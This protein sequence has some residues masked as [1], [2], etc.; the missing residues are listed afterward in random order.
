MKRFLPLAALLFVL[1]TP[2]TAFSQVPGEIS[3]QGML[4]GI[5]GTV[6][7]TLRLYAAEVGGTV[8][9]TENHPTVTLTAGG[10]F[11]LTLG[12]IQPM[13][14]LQ[15]DRQYWLEVAVNG[16]IL[17]P[18]TRIVTS[19]Y[20]FRAQTAN[21]V[22]NNAI[23]PDDLKI[24]GSPAQNN[25][26][27]MFDGATGRFKWGALGGGGGG[28]IN[29][30]VEGDGIQIDG[31]TGPS[32]T[33][34]IA[35]EGITTAMLAN[36]AVTGAKIGAETITAAN[37]ADATITQDKFAPNVGLPSVGT[38]GGALTGNYPNPGIAN[39]A[40]ATANLATNAVTT[41][42]IADDAVTS[43]KI[44][45]GAVN[46]E[47][48]NS[49]ANFSLTSLRASDSL[50][51]PKLTVKGNSTLDGT[52][53]IGTAPATGKRLLIQGAGATTATNSLEI[54][55]NAGT[56]LFTVRDDGNVGVGTNAPVAGLEIRQPAGTG[57]AVTSGST[58]FSFTAVN[59][60]P[61]IAIPAST[62]VVQINSDGAPGS[63]NAVTMPAAALPGEIL[64]ITNG[65]NDPTTGGAVI[66]AGQAGIFVFLPAPVNAWRR[67]N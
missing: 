18:R 1:F 38:A 19:P 21:S 57:L 17:S 11:S 6:D 15:F 64:I 46:S 62:T 2:R 5:S 14:N 12:S 43:D 40:V 48:V 30:L 32:S 9:W 44:A 35:N 24:T 42:K 8:L 10:T 41:V 7:L 16:T 50:G 34:S 56:P 37:I 26:A 55:D 27:L 53:G 23:E 3:Y 61:A 20:A 13:T 67:V 66:A 22:A 49:A 4:S 36:G 31:L 63:P 60:G 25:Q 65:D 59:A 51:T 52:V 45:A 29:Q 33:I 54:R 47:H 58:A 28:A 39:D